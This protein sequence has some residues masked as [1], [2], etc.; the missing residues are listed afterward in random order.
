MQMS[1]VRGRKLSGLTAPGL[2]VSYSYDDSG[3]RTAKT[4]NGVTTS[5]L[6]SGSSILRMTKGVDVLDFYFDASGN[7]IGFRYNGADYWYVRNGQGD[8]TGILNN[9]G[10]QVV[11]YTYDA[12][13]KPLSVTGT[14]ASTIGQLNPLRYRGY[15]LDTETGFYYLQSRYYDPQVGRFL[16]ADEL[17]RFG[18]VASNLLSYCENNPV[19]KVDLSGYASH[20]V[21]REQVENSLTAAR[22][23]IDS[24]EVMRTNQD[25]NGS[26]EVTIIEPHLRDPVIGQ[27]EPA[28][29]YPKSTI[30]DRM[31]DDES[32]R[33]W[34]EMLE[35][36]ST[37]A[38]GAMTALGGVGACLGGLY[39][40]GVA[41]IA[42]G[43]CL[44]F[45]GL[46]KEYTSMYKLIKYILFGEK[47]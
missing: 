11:T 34:G 40:I 45:Y 30:W 5:Y 36:F 13:G 23:T 35:G 12:W 7:A 41:G 8:I 15:V 9:S 14:M 20:E 17:I 3:I 22:T 28:Q 31:F 47:K 4:V 32:K 18:E 10:T 26:D 27:K 33:L 43:A 39:P 2:A 16:N 19:N 46:Y 38:Q 24:H 25:I 29:P 37:G 6:L 42:V 44:F 1:W 21:A